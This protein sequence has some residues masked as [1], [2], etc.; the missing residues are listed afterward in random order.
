MIGEQSQIIKCKM[1]YVTS[2]V[3]TQSLGVL[4][5]FDNSYECLESFKDGAGR[6]AIAVI[7]NDVEKF[8]VVNVYY[9]CEISVIFTEV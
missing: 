6:M 4:I 9:P 8:I 7:E 1:N 2:C 3:S 5:L